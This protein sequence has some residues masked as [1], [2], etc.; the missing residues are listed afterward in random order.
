MVNCSGAQKISRP[1]TVEASPTLFGWGPATLSTNQERTRGSG[2]PT[3][4]L[5]RWAATGRKG[6]R[7]P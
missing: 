1:N 4:I 6:Y 5:I 2:S 3:V 7:A